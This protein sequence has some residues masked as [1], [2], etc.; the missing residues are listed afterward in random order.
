MSESIEKMSHS[1]IAEMSPEELKAKNRAVFRRLI[2][3]M[4]PYKARFAM[5]VFFG[6][7]AGMSNA[8]VL[9][10]MRA[11]FKIILNPDAP[12]KIEPF[13]GLS[14]VPGELRKISFTPPDFIADNEW[15][16]TA[17]ACSLIPIVVLGRG[18]LG[19]MHTYYFLWIEQRM[20]LSMRVEAFS[21]LLRQSIEWYSK[22]N[23]AL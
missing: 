5:G 8:I 22:E 20:M 2:Q 18:L 12:R 15:A 21:G 19:F 23:R 3:Y 7:I 1:D 4:K 9:F 10:T 17:F 11:V 14:T 6:V 13:A 16:F